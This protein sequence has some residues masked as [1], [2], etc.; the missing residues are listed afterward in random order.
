MEL[1]ASD[2]IDIES[3]L[4]QKMCSRFSRLSARVLGSA[5]RRMPWPV[6]NEKTRR[7]GELQA[8]LSFCKLKYIH[9]EQRNRERWSLVR[10]AISVRIAINDWIGIRLWT[11]K[12]RTTGSVRILCVNWTKWNREKSERNEIFPTNA[13]YQWVIRCNCWCRRHISQTS[14]RH[15]RW[16]HICSL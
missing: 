6:L 14:I 9:F 8:S 11:G 7:S 1:R 2:L 13:L 5:K 16:L 15:H 10:V 12:Y 3:R 4:W